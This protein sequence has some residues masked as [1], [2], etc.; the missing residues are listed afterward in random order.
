MVLSFFLTS[1]TLSCILHLLLSTTKRLLS[2]S[3]FF[4]NSLLLFVGLMVRINY[5][6]GIT[7]VVFKHSLHVGNNVVVIKS[8][9]TPLGN[10]RLSSANGAVTTTT[11]NTSNKAGVVVVVY[12]V[13][14]LVASDSEVYFLTAQ[15]ALPILFLEKAHAVS[16][17]L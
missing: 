15:W 6:L 12:H 2:S 14:R 3:L 16:S 13:V 11:E 7:L 8:L 17:E 10:S 4:L 9:L 5:R 1:K